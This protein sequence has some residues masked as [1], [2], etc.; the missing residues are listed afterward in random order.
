LVHLL[1]LY[2]LSPPPYAP[3]I[4]AAAAETAEPT[5]ELPASASAWWWPLTLALILPEWLRR[6]HGHGALAEVGYVLLAF[7]H[8]LLLVRRW[9]AANRVLVPD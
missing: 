2:L 9:L 6:S 5:V 3:G 4:S 7:R 1:L 8:H